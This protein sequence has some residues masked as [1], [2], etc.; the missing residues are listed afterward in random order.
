MTLLLASLLAMAPAQAVEPVSEDIHSIRKGAV[1]MCGFSAPDVV[2]YE[3]TVRA[4]DGW[5]EL[6][7]TPGYTAVAITESRAV[8]TFTTPENRTFPAAVCR[9]VVAAEGGGSTIRMHMVCDSDRESCDWLFREFE[10]LNKRIF[11]DLE[12]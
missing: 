10:A 2:S 9:E 5:E 4:S 1:E 7:G 6:N 11:D 3:A 12:K 8:I